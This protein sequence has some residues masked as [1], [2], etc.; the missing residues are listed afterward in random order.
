MNFEI[1]VEYTQSLIHEA[2]LLSMKKHW[3][4]TLATSFMAT[5]LAF[6]ILLTLFTTRDVELL[7]YL[8]VQYRAWSVA[9]FVASI[10]L[11]TILYFLLIQVASYVRSQRLSKKSLKKFQHS[12]QII[13]FTLES[14]SYSMDGSGTTILWKHLDKV[15]LGTSI[16]LI[17]VNS[18]NCLMIPIEKL[19]N[20]QQT[21]I[22]AN[23]NKHHVKTK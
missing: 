1:S 14:I 22:K 17:Y 8:W 5:M 4:R 12:T 16:W 3:Q 9:G 11:I 18:I 7:L 6:V 15:F 21:S 20:E 10:V 23:L 2:T 19:S 13:Q